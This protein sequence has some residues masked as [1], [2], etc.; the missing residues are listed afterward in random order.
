MLLPSVVID[1]RRASLASA[2]AAVST[3]L[4]FGTGLLKTPS[5][6]SAYAVGHYFEAECLWKFER[7]TTTCN[8]S[9]LGHYIYLTERLA[10]TLTA[11]RKYK[12]AEIYFDEALRL[13]QEKFGQ[14]SFEIALLLN[15]M[16]GMYESQ[17]LLDKAEDVYRQALRIDEN[18]NTEEHLLSSAYPMNNLG[19][20][21]KRRG[22][23]V[24]AK[25]VLTNALEI[26]AKMLGIQDSST[27]VTQR[28]LA[29]L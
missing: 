6:V 10:I 27:Q 29:L 18:S 3:L 9:Q 17:N 4:F 28:N 19:L 25:R 23:L 11:E 2:L 12:E 26:R 1:R 15:K 24:E 20:C 13:K 14:N 8:Q 22:R 5:A 21:L 16:A 7:L